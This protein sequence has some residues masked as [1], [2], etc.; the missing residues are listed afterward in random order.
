MVA[1]AKAIGSDARIIILDEPTSALL[2][3]EV[4]ILFGHMRRLASEGHSFL[5][6]SHRLAEVFEIADRVTVLRDG[7]RA[8]AW[9]RE[10]MSRKTIIKAIVGGDKPWIDDAD[11]GRADHGEPVFVA[12]ALAGGRVRDLSFE[13]RSGEILGFAGLPGSG[14]EEALDLLFARS[15]AS[16][17]QLTAHGKSLTLRS[18]RDAKNAGIALVPKNRHAESL[19]SGASVRENISL[20]NLDRFV[21]DPVA[22]FIRRSKERAEGKEI[23]TRLA[24][25]MSSIEASIDSL[26]GGNQQKAILGRWLASGAKI[27]MLNSP[28][29]AVDIGAKADIYNL[30]RE[31][32]ASGAGV[33]FTSTEVEEFPRVCHRIIVFRD[34]VVVG[35]LA[36]ANATEA[37]IMHLAV[38]GEDER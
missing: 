23:A 25:K 26:S 16:G 22:R 2:P 11:A 8:G 31:I 5:Y 4:S 3:A 37:N 34:G 13:L 20:P 32:A 24:I 27:F 28:T 36:G 35:E 21:T 9:T 33:I 17:G 7:R 30:I 38:G 14:A 19:L 1:I 15:A 6:V 29:A 12:S 18:P 10:Q